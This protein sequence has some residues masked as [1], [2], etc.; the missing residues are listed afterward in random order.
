MNILVTGCSRG[1]GL[2]IC[3]VFLEQCH[4]VYGVAR[5]HTEEFKALEAEYAGKLFF[6]SVDLSERRSLRSS[7]EIKSYCTL[8]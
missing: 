4:V 1:V 7:L 2:E 6:K 8:M 3:K 5:S